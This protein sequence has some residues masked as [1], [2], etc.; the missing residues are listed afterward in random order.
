MKRA[1]IKG[2]LV[3]IES[4]TAEGLKDIYKPFNAYGDELV[5]KLRAFKDNGVHVLG[6]FIFGLPS[7]KP[8]TFDATAI[9][10]P[11]KIRRQ[12]FHRDVVVPAY[13]CSQFLQAGRSPCHD[14]EVVAVG[15]QTVGEVLADA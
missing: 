6:S 7:D 12:D 8:S 2:A 5:A 14:H 10:D 15:R 9:I 1:R 11:R 13:L 4:V 3:G